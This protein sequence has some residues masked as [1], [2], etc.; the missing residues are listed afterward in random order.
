ME[1]Q[2]DGALVGKKEKRFEL[3]IQEIAKERLDAFRSTVMSIVRPRDSNQHF[4]IFGKIQNLKR[5]NGSQSN[6]P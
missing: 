2:S 4:F 5:L 6:V 3:P 1:Q